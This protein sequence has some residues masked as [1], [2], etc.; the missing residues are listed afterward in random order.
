[1]SELITYDY[2]LFARKTNE[3]HRDLNDVAV[4]T[5]SFAYNAA[6]DLTKLTDG[7]A[8]TTT[9]NYD[10]FGRVT[11]K[12]DATSA[13]LFR[14]TYDANGRFTT[15]WTPAKLTTAYSYDAMGN[16]TL[17]NYPA[18]PTS[19]WPTMEIIDSHPWWTPSEPPPT[20]TQP[21]EAC[22]VKTALGPMTP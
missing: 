7:K 5:N 19:P 21:S 1:L 10:Q 6:G 11:N 12:L 20:V 13:E 17:I 3:V 18:S 2:D 16:L 9:W 14:Y 15:R 8:Q 22:R 4:M